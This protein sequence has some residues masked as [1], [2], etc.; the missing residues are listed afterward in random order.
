MTAFVPVIAIAVSVIN[1]AMACALGADAAHRLRSGRRVAFFGPVLW[2]FATWVGSFL[3]I[4][5]YWTMHYSTLRH[6]DEF[7]SR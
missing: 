2:F 4:A 1:L 5:L 6:A 3:A 7:P